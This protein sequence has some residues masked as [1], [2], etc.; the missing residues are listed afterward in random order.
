MGDYSE[1]K[2]SEEYIE[3]VKR[4]AER[5]ERESVP[6]HRELIQKYE[7]EKSYYSEKFRQSVGVIIVI[8]LAFLF[9]KYASFRTE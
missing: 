6:S 4:E 3:K 1:P 7:L 8:V 9:V 2:T 5:M